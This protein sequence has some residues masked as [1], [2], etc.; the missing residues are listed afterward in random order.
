VSRGYAHV[1]ANARGTGGSS[2]T[3][4]MMDATERA[5]IHDVIEWV[6][7]QDWCDGR[8][9]MIG[10]SYFGMAQLMAAVEAP[11]SLRAV[12]PFAAASGLHQAVYHG[13]ILSDLFFGGW[14][15][16][17]AMLASRGR[18]RALR[19]RPAEALW[20]LLNAEPVHRR[21]EGFDGEAAIAGVGKLMRLGFD[22]EPWED[23][24]Q[25]ATAGHPR[26]DGF[27]R[28]R[29]WAPLLGRSTVP[30]HL[31]C[32]WDNV[33]LH[34]S[35]AFTAWEALPDRPGHR[36]SLLGPGGLSWPWETMHTEALAWYDH[37]LKDRDTGA[38]E[39]API[40]YCLRGA[41]G[42]RKLESWPP[43]GLDTEELWLRADG[44]LAAAAGS[45][46]RDYLF[47]PPAVSR[48]GNA[49]R[50]TL[51][52]ALVWDT[53]PRGT[54]YDVVGAAELAL[55]AT[56]NAAEV[57]WIAKL[58]LLDAGGTA[59]D[60]TQGWLRVR[61]PEHARVSLVPTAVRVRPGERLRLTLTSNDRDGVAMTGFTH[62]PLAAP[63]LQHVRAS[64]RLLLPIVP[65]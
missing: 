60:L 32:P 22:R 14:L 21:F 11:P 65:S 43:P 33:P 24:Y 52:T 54:A 62:L 10:V 13:G 9:G 37:W 48:P 55:D 41:D 5:D 44:T 42:Y 56:S 36:L 12:F 2:G 45:G 53:E 15:A 3:Y 40:R 34:L 19:S 28:E 7:A 50:P 29:D 20:K 35:G 30:M 8:V 38:L 4:T 18:W 59:H 63:S 6:A 25:A 57:D 27:W 46:G 39:G 23:L 26:Y 17:V 51:P 16:G 49:P 47:V 58:S 1:I 61:E 31:G 64:S